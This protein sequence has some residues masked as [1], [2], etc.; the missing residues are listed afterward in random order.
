MCTPDMLIALGDLGGGRGQHP[1]RGLR[2]RAG[3]HQQPP[4]RHGRERHG[5][6][7]LGVVVPARLHEGFRPA[8]VEH[9]LA[10]AVRFQ[11]ARRA[12]GDVAAKLEHQVARRPAGAPAHRSG[13]L[14]RLQEGVREKR[15]ERGGIGIGAGIPGLGRD[16]GDLRYDLDLCGTRSAHLTQTLSGP[17]QVASILAHRAG[18]VL[19]AAHM[20]RPGIAGADTSIVRQRGSEK[21]YAS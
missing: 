20:P 16:V 7:Q 10:L 13:I 2:H 14:Q 11:V 17:R 21:Y 12:T 18:N 1:L 4:A 3:A 5:D 6:L 8:V 15:I 19:A 9:V